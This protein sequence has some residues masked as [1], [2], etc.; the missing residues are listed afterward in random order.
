MFTCIHIYTDGAA[1]T[2]QRASSRQFPLE[3]LA[4]CG[5]LGLHSKRAAE[6]SRRVGLWAMGVAWAVGF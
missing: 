5:L 1:Q 2:K 4:A 3:A 6:W